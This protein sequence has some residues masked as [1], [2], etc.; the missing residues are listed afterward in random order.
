MILSGV[1]NFFLVII[2]SNNIFYILLKKNAQVTPMFQIVA[3]L[4]KQLLF[5]INDS[6]KNPEHWVRVFVTEF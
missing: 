2:L 4:K 5:V 1:G 6:L 3:L